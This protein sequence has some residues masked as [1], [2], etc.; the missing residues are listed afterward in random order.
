M[1]RQDEHF[2]VIRHCNRLSLCR[3]T[4]LAANVEAGNPGPNCWQLAGEAIIYPTHSLHMHELR[5]CCRSKVII[6]KRITVPFNL[7]RPSE[8]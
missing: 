3:D 8:Y 7:V 4:V 2:E 6:K 5:R 1:S